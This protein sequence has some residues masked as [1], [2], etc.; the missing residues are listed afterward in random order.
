MSIDREGS[1]PRQLRVRA[2]TPLHLTAEEM[3]RRQERYDRL[4]GDQVSVTLVNLDGRAPLR[5]ETPEDVATSDGYVREEIARTDPER[6]DVIMPDCVLDPGVGEI[7]HTPVPLVGILRLAAG[8]IAS[9]G[10]V[11]AAVARNSAIGNELQRRIAAYGLTDQLVSMELLDVDFCFVSDEAGWA[12]AMRPIERSLTTRGISTV[13][14]GC[15]AVE[16]PDPRPGGS[17][18]VDPT[19]LA[20]RLLALAAGSGL[21][22]SRA[23]S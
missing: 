10:G 14:N 18:V 21:V 12:Q 19:R 8:H 2:I 15:S 4:G 22:G 1:R 16:I 7:D 23:S 9:L 3:V 11:F 17:V 5:L 6:F 13:L 20:V